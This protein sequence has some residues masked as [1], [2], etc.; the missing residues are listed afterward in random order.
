MFFKFRSGTHGLFE[1][2][3]RHDGRG[4]SQECPICGDCKESVEHVLF[5]CPSYDSQRQIFLRYLKQVL[6]PEAFDTFFHSSI[7]D[8]TVFCLGEK[9]GIVVNDECSSW[10]Y[11]VGEFLQSVWDR[12][13]S[14]LYKEGSDCVDGQV[15]PTPECEVNGID[16]YDS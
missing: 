16:C 14:I 6:I 15:N 9:Q 8:K 3:G 11:R 1:E 12:R 7:F 4:G 13:K 5:E 10:Y 2:L